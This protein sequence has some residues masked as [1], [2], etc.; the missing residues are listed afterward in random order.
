MT[1]RAR[2]AS[3]EHSTALH[4]QKQIRQL[5]GEDSTQEPALNGAIQSVPNASEAVGQKVMQAFSGS[6]R[7]GTGFTSLPLEIRVLIA[8]HLACWSDL[9]AYRLVDSANRIVLQPTCIAHIKNNPLSE[10]Q[11]RVID[12]VSQLWIGTPQKHACSR[13]LFRR[14]L[15]SGGVNPELIVFRE[16]ENRKVAG[17][18]EEE[19]EEEEEGKR[20]VIHGEEAKL[21]EDTNLRWGKNKSPEGIGRDEVRGRNLLVILRKIFAEY[22][23]FKLEGFDEKNISRF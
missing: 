15:Q 1:H 21:V 11:R 8:E 16:V 23:V 4:D 9:Q 5:E 18:E 6:N 22:R 19:E 17:Q 3:T 13:S 7:S 12:L 10:D 2:S 14:L 20:T